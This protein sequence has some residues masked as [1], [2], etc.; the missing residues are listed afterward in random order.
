MPNWEDRLDPN[1]DFVND[2]FS[3][4]RTSPKED[5]FAHNIF[6]Q[7]PYD[8][9]LM[10]MNIFGDKVTLNGTASIKGYEGK[11]IRNY[12]K[13][14]KNSKIKVICDCGAFSYINDDKPPEKYDAAHVSMMYEKLAFDYGV[15]VDHMMNKNLSDEENEERRQLSLKNA[16]DFIKHCK[17]KKY[18]FTPIGAAQG[19]DIPS[20]ANS[21]RKLIDMGYSYIGIGSLIPRTDQFIVELLQAI[22]T[23]VKKSGVKIHL[24]GVLRRDSLKQ[25]ERWNASSFDSA[26]YFRKAWLKSDNNYLGVDLEWYSAIR[27]PIADGSAVLN[28]LTEKGLTLSGIQKQESTILKLLNEYDKG[29]EKILEELLQKVIIY[30]SVLD[31]SSENIHKFE[32]KYRHLLESKIWKRCSCEMCKSAGINTVIF[33][34]ANRNKRRGFHNTWIFY[35]NYIKGASYAKR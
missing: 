17:K 7:A 15:S 20:Y 14:R 35:N 8:G 4:E 5:V 18:S 1:F 19:L 22:S 11:T 6:E 3:A 21:V 24:F 10:S 32:P 13:L 25:F 33:R 34:R 9:I 30:D 28:T 12:L 29:N 26:S 23:P 27:V 16:D 31:R 2:C